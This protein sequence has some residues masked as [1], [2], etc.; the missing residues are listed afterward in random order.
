MPKVPTYDAPQVE[1]RPAPNAR[2]SSAASPD[3][4]NA[5]VRQ[6][7]DLGQSLTRAGEGMRQ[8]AV[9]LQAREDADMLFRAETAFKDEYQRHEED[10]TNN[11]TGRAAWGVTRDT[12][13]WFADQA[14][15]H[16]E[17]LTSD[18]QRKLFDQSITKLRQH[19]V[20]TLSR[21]EAGERRRSLE[22]AETASIAG[23]ISLAARQA[24]LGFTGG[25]A[26]VDEAGNPLPAVN[27][28]AGFRDDIV[29]RVRVVADVNK[30][31]PEREAFETE[32][33]LTNLHSQII[34]NL[35]AKSPGKAKEY[36]EANKAEINGASYDAIE[37]SLK[38][39]SLREVAQGFADDVQGRKMGMED[40]LAEAR[41]KF[42]GD[43][44]AAAVAEVKTR[45]SEADAILR[46]GQ[47]QSADTAWR[48]VAGGGGRGQIPL[49]T[50]NSMSGPDQRHVLDY[51]EA[52]TRKEGI[53]TDITAWMEAH[54]GIAAGT[55][56]NSSDLMR[57]A[58]RVSTNDLQ[59]LAEK[60]NRPDRVAEVKVDSDDFNHIAQLAGLKPFAAKSEEEKAAIGDLRY[61]VEQ[62]IITAQ[63]TKKAPLSR[64][65]KLM[66]MQRE[67]DNKVMV[68]VM[69]SD[70][71]KPALLLKED[72][73]R[74]AYVNVGKEQVYLSAIPA[75]ERQR[76]ID[77]RRRAG[78]PVTE[79]AIADY[80]VRAG[81]PGGK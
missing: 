79:Q 16:S 74:K 57:Y 37:R 30:W 70:P 13:K 58:S 60:M 44:E 63:Q 76:I 8:V 54:D 53:K 2:Q 23:T 21:F 59:Q 34:Q 46:Q 55:I 31:T 48:V 80:W 5:G 50:W 20:G 29:K 40:A 49:K 10:I 66:L 64:D 28:V 35:A 47:Q 61:K 1:L 56:K 33:H 45:F 32:K 65:E 69:F 25:P 72:E 39:G 15:K 26:R 77:A 4:L 24:S 42:S 81:K 19:A 18:T 78:L 12:E 36:F 17:G 22:E 71:Q 52:K 73:Q 3:L 7:M 14:R 43:E 27:P 51:L 11:R 6:Q 41:K 9:T 68:D 75:G 62:R 67:I 38:E